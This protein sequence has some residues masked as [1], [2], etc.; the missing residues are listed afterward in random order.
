MTDN[1]KIDALTNLKFTL[2][3][4]VTGTLQSLGTPPQVMMTLYVGKAVDPGILVQGKLR[5]MY[6]RVRKQT[7]K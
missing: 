1:G 6:V 3:D 5:P 7:L 2:N 4:M